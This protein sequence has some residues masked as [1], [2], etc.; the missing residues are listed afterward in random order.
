M[1]IY[2]RAMNNWQLCPKCG[3]SNPL[4]TLCKGTQVISKVTG[5]PPE[6]VTAVASASTTHLHPRNPKPKCMSCNQEMCMG[7]ALNGTKGLIPTCCNSACPSKRFNRNVNIK[8]FM[9]CMT[10]SAALRYLPTR[11]GR[12]VLSCPNQQCGAYMKEVTTHIDSGENGY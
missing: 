2:I 7:P 12:S 6:R 9:C 3:G 4:C 5:L 8:G 11:D 10:C 1:F